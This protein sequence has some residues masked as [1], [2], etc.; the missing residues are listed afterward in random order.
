[1]IKSDVIYFENGGMII[2]RVVAQ[3]FYAKNMRFSSS[4]IFS[5]YMI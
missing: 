1:M 3:V 2:G 4:A 5:I